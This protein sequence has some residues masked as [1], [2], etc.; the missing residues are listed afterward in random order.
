M[1]LPAQLIDLPILVAI[2]TDTLLECDKREMTMSRRLH[3]TVATGARF[4][5][6]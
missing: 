6:M 2:G 5:W 3:K 1:R 4:V